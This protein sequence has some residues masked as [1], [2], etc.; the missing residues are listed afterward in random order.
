MKTQAKWG[1]EEAE[2]E[3]E[4][5]EG[6]KEKTCSRIILGVKKPGN[7]GQLP[8]VILGRPRTHLLPSCSPSTQAEGSNVTLDGQYPAREEQ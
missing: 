8:S 5:E 7:E 4:E 6:R 3:E 2:A 1:G